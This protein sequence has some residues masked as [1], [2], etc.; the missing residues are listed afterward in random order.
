MLDGLGEH[1][2]CAIKVTI[3]GLDSANLFGSLFDPSNKMEFIVTGVSDE[4]P[5]EIDIASEVF[6]HH[7]DVAQIGEYFGLSQENLT[8]SSARDFEIESTATAIT[9]RGLDNVNISIQSAPDKCSILR[10]IHNHIGEEQILELRY[11]AG[12]PILYYNSSNG[13]ELII[14]ESEC[15]DANK[16][17]ELIDYLFSK[18]G[19]DGQLLAGP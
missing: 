12:I 2:L 8:I 18:Y 14:Y 5:I 17:T 11:R 7:V 13:K 16:L 6:C 15:V 4:D 10:Q 1:Q 3:E 19:G 9:Q